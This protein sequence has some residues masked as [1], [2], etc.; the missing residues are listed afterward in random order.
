VQAGSG[1]DAVRPLRQAVG[2]HGHCVPDVR[3]DIH[4]H[5]AFV[6]RGTDERVAAA[7]FFNTTITPGPQGYYLYL[8]FGSMA[9]LFYMYAMLLKGKPTMTPVN[10]DYGKARR[11]KFL[12]KNKFSAYGSES[13]NTSFKRRKPVP[14]AQITRTADRR[15]PGTVRKTATKTTATATR[16]VTRTTTTTRTTARTAPARNPITDGRRT[17]TGPG[18]TRPTSRCRP[19]SSITGVSI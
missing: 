2:R 16:N 9:F 11:A 12:Q 7:L 6:L 10:N 3:G 5:P 15:R 1:H 18:D 14:R 19:R 4:A 8:Y 17:T 13:G